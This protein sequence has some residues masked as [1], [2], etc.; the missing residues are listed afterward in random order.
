ML[1][2]RLNFA[3]PEGTRAVRGEYHWSRRRMRTATLF[4]CPHNGLALW[5]LEHFGQH[6]NGKHLPAWVLTMPEEWRRAL[7]DGYVS[8]DGNRYRNGVAT[9]TISR[10]LATGIMLLAASLGFHPVVG[11]N[12]RT[13]YTIEGRSGAMHILYHVRWS[14]NPVYAC[15]EATENHVW[16][17]ITSI[18]LGRW[19]AEVFN[20]SVEEDESYVADGMIVHNCTNHSLAKGRGRRWLGQLPLTTLVRRAMTRQR[21]AHAAPCGTRCAGRSGTA[22]NW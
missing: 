21:N 11:V 4:D 9:N 20:L 17:R 8:A 5:L 16:E 13:R 12:T 10:S 2:A 14:M 7:L 1:E 6:A 3:L 15:T 19:Q 22:T 18:T